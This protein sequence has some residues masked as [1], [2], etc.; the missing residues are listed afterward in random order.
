[1]FTFLPR[2][3][4]HGPGFGSFLRS[5]ENALGDLDVLKRQVALVGAQL[6]GFGAELIAPEFADDHFESAPRFFRLGERCLMI[7]KRL[8]PDIFCGQDGDI[9]A[10]LQSQIGPLT[11]SAAVALIGGRD[12]AAPV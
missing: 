5:I 2:H 10:P 9:H 4:P 11:G 1:M 7:G 12:L 3:A 6:L 8:Q